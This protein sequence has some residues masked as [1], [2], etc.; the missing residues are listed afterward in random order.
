MLLVNTH[1]HSTI[2][3][4]RQSP[5]R[6][7]KEYK[8][9]GYD[10]VIMTDH[11]MVETPYSYPDIEGII[12]INGC[13]VSSEEHYIYARAGDEELRIKC[14]PNRYNDPIEEVEEWNLYETTEHARLQEKYFK[15]RD[16]YPL[17]S[18]D[19]HDISHIGRAGILVQSPPDPESIIKNIKI[20]NF[21]LWASKVR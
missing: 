21:R 17:F 6:M 1:T 16:N 3:D 11:A 15:C 19:S 4:G 13:E 14:H 18:D 10:A 12:T 7:I 8:K 2:S 20:G 9:H 5:K